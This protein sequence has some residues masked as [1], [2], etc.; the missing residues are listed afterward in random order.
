[1]RE[2][3]A[4]RSEKA[5]A[6]LIGLET[7]GQQVLAPPLAVR[8]PHASDLPFLEV[9]RAAGAILVTC[10]LRHFPKSQRAGVTVMSPG[11][12]LEL[13]SRIP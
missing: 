6:L 8:L 10:N 1:L 13:L 11:D 2:E 12:F 3:F 9:A 7:V 5:L 4:F